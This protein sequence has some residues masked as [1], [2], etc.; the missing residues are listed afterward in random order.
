MRHGMDKGK[1]AFCDE[2]RYSE[3][4]FATKHFLALYDKKPLLPGHCLV[5]SKRHVVDINE[6]SPE[7]FADLRHILKSVLPGLAKVYGDCK[8]YNLVI[9][10]GKPAGASIAHFH[11]HIVP[12]KP[13]DAYANDD[14]IYKDIDTKA[15]VLPRKAY[16]AEVAKLR[17]YLRYKQKAPKGL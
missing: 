14:D 10:R 15:N 16:L 9:Q 12:R 2:K 13:N 4:F 8:S 5:V 17:K 6:L 3:A 1:D 11:I 7:E